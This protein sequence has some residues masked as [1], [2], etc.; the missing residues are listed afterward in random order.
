[1]AKKNQHAKQGFGVETPQD[2]IHMGDGKRIRLEDV[3]ESDANGNQ[4]VGNRGYND[5]RY[6]RRSDDGSPTVVLSYQLVITSSTTGIASVTWIDGDFDF[7]VVTDQPVTFIGAPSASNFRIDLLQAHD[8]GTISIKSGMEGDLDTVEAPSADAGAIGVVTVLWNDAGEGQIQDVTT[9][10]NDDFDQKRYSTKI[11]PNTTGKYAKMWE[12]TLG[13]NHNYGIII[14][15]QEPISIDPGVYAGIGSVRLY[16]S[17]TCDPDRN[18]VSETVQFETIGGKTSLG[19]FLLVQVEG[20]KAALY[21]RS[22]QYWGRVQFRITFH[23]T[24]VKKKDFVNNGPYGDPPSVTVGSW[25]SSILTNGAIP[26]IKGFLYEGGPQEFELDFTPVGPLLVFAS[27]W[28]LDTGSGLAHTVDGNVVTVLSDLPVNTFIQIFHFT[29]PIEAGSVSDVEAAAITANM[30]DLQR[31]E[32]GGNAANDTAALNLSTISDLGTIGR[33]NRT[34]AFVNDLDR[35]GLFVW[36]NEALT[37]DG[38]TIFAAAGG[39]FWVRQFSGPRN[40]KWY[41]VKGDGVTDEAALVQSIINSLPTE[42]TTSYDPAN[43]GKRNSLYFPPGTY[44]FKD[45]ISLNGN[46]ELVSEGAK[47]V[48]SPLTN[49]DF[50]KINPNGWNWSSSQKI[51]MNVLIKGLSILGGYDPLTDT[52]NGEIGLNLENLAFSKLEDIRI[53]GFR[54]NIKWGK[55]TGTVGMYYNS[56]EQVISRRSNLHLDFDQNA[57]F[58]VTN[59]SFS[60]GSGYKP[61]L[62]NFIK[63]N[64]AGVSFLSCHIEN[65]VTLADTNFAHIDVVGG[66]VTF[67]GGYSEGGTYFAQ[68]DLSTYVNGAGLIEIDP[69]NTTNGR[70]Y[71]YNSSGLKN[72]TASS[73]ARFGLSSFGNFSVITKNASFQAGRNGM[74]VLGGLSAAYEELT[75]LSGKHSLRVEK[76]ST[77]SPQITFQSV[78]DSYGLI[79]N[80]HFVVYNPDNHDITMT[81]FD[82][83]DGKNSGG[84]RKI[85]EFDNGIQIYV[86]RLVESI[87]AGPTITF[88]MGSTVPVGAVVNLISVHVSDTLNYMPIKQRSLKT[89]LDATPTEGAFVKGDLVYNASPDEGEFSQWQC[90]T[91]GQ[92][93]TGTVPVLKG[94]GRIG[95][96]TADSI[97]NSVSGYNAGV[98]QKLEHDASGVKV[99]V[100]I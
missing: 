89:Y 86:K 9:Q 52:G 33:K 24:D 76:V 62:T 13:S 51:K 100:N 22:S 17:F 57:A 43:M 10:K 15:C 96:E 53:S 7:N 25:E 98:A 63:V 60:G 91:T 16:L 73:Y 35:G 21:H 45:S 30:L 66:M 38:G 93:G 65:T 95:G 49:I 61:L 50:I 82:N 11:S 78:F 36:S 74:T 4:Q 31:D 34:R 80:V 56:M 26:K 97:L 20:N 27:G 47:F 37:A 59:C 67:K 1:M 41:G 94:V 72:Q 6:M 87:K 71:Y 39:G 44:M 12:G 14:D 55:L 3:P 28:N 68:V 46:M 18:I 85:C 8:D 77:T 69:V 75:T 40:T 70:I 54:K 81:L 64:A 29:G 2:A 84:L 79:N 42:T 99:W 23:N 90:V 32:A 19:N 92:F 58:T 5:L 88:Q 83:V 48:F